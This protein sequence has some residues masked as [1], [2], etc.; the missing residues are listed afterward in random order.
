MKK[1]KEKEQYNSDLTHQ[2][3]AYAFEGFAYAAS[4]RGMNI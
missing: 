1:A 3:N 4:D 2:L